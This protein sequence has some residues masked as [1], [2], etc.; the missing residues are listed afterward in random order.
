M[1]RHQCRQRCR[2]DG[3]ARAGQEL[4]AILLNIGMPTLNG[5]E[6]CRRIRQQAWSKNIVVIALT[7]WGQEEDINAS[8]WPPAST[9]AWS[10]LECYCQQCV[11]SLPSNN[12]PQGP[13]RD[14]AVSRANGSGPGQDSK[15]ATRRTI[16]TFCCAEH[17]SLPCNPL[18]K[19]FNAAA[20][21]ATTPSA[22]LRW[23]YTTP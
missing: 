12:R 13:G 22:S 1:T 23:Q 9:L 8:R 20:G 10:S 5:Y 3:V 17:Q 14:G 18:C 7:G 2:D 19:R 21:S 16:Q 6:V 4:D 11:A 15:I